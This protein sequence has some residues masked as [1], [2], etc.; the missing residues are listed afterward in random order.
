MLEGDKI[1]KTAIE[2]FGRVDIIINNAGIL[3]DVSF[4]R[5]TQRDWDLIFD[6]HC[7]GAYAVTRAAWPYMRDQ[8]YGRIINTSSAAGLYGNFGQG[9]YSAAKM[10]LVG[11]TTALAKEGAAKNVFVNAIAPLAGSR[12]TATVM[13]AE[14][15][16]RLK[17]E[18]VSPLVAYLCHESSKENGNIYEVGAGWV[19]KVRLQRSAGVFM[20]LDAVT[21][22][23]VA[24]SIEQIGKF[25]ERA[26]YPLT[27]QQSMGPVMTNLEKFTN[28]IV[29]VIVSFVCSFN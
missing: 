24:A 19:A 20:P 16:D 10:A 21:A 15:V 18:Y 11:F 13:P 2:K 23:R 27:T 25:D 22:E 14:L 26:D 12:M 28:Y 5:M 17:P 1:V 7:K 9:N 4:H 29:I 8:G 3:R 6:V